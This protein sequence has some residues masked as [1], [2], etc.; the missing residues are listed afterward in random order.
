MRR[1]RLAPWLRR[2]LE[3]AVVAAIVA[4][5]S[6]AGNRLAAGAGPYPLPA[7]PAGGLV[8]APEVLA[9]GV[10]TCAY[11]LAMAATRSDAVFGAAVAF[12]VAADLTIV[13]GAGP[14][15]LPD[16]ESQ[17]SGGAFVALLG[18]G[19]ALVGLVAGQVLT[20]LGFGRRAG[21]VAAILAAVAA[22]GI[23]VVLGMAR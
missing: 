11:P 22:T 4:V 13:F 2:G 20:P 3:A 12:L 18:A 8:L 6:L 10:L 15:L 5:A 19:P 23:L 9:L 1:F 14:L 7:G 17:V 21:A 16:G